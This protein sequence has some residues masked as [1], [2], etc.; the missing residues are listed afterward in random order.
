M[1][2]RK[3]AARVMVAAYSTFLTAPALAACEVASGPNTTALVELYTSEGCSSCPPADRRLR[4]L[5]EELGAQANA[6]ALALHVGY[7]D[8]IGWKDPF[9]QPGFAERQ[10]RLVH[11]NGHRTVYTPHFFVAGTELR[12][13]RAALRDEVRRL[14]D[15]PAAAAIRL[16]ARLSSPGMLAIE[17][18]ASSAAKAEPLAL[19]VALTESGLVSK[20]ARGENAG[21]TLEHDHVV[22]AWLGPVRLSGGGAKLVR[23]LALPAAWR[24]PRVALVAFVQDELSGRVLQ[25]VSARQCAGS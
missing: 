19:H 10:T 25:A 22:R 12:S 2:P 16:R 18:R 17:A 7:W 8:Y 14:N 23:E 24:R 4:Q 15:T 11:A 6:V 20:V 5:G 21:V 1:H 3:L 9:A 13:P